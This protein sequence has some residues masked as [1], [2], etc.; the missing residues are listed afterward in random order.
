MVSDK[1]R[2]IPGFPAPL[3]T[4]VEHMILSHHGQLEYGSPKLPQFPEA[5]LLHFL[6][7]MDSKMEC[8]RG[9][10]E[11]DRLV[12]GC[13]TGFHPALDRS[14]LKKERYLSGETTAAPR[15]PRPAAVPV[16]PAMHAEPANGIEPANG[17][18]LA[19]PPPVAPPA[20]AAHPLFA[21]KPD[22][23]FADKLKQALQEAPSGSGLKQDD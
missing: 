13:F 19:P 17:V 16:E 7:D 6:D 15:P 9:L 8:M 22:S 3:R 20:M 12:E 2:T 21:P 23:P 14:V 18:P 5:L 10:I 11:R 1:V 4:L